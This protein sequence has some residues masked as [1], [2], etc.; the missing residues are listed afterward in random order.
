MSLIGKRF[1]SLNN[2]FETCLMVWHSNVISLNLPISE[3]MLIAQAKIF[4][5]RIGIAELEFRY[6]NGWLRNFKKRYGVCQRTISG[7]AK[8]LITM[9]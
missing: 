8:V 6:S 3:N 9:L 5:E 7:E 4:G 1:E 2:Q